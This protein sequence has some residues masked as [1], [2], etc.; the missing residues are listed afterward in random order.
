VSNEAFC[1]ING[2]IPIRI[3]IEEIGKMFEITQGI[4]TQ[5]YREVDLDNWNHPATHIKTIEKDE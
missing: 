3:K 5:Y 4:G 1:L 2:I